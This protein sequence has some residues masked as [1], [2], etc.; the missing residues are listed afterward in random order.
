[1]SMRDPENP[2]PVFDALHIPP[3]ALEQGG[4]EVLRAVIVE[5]DLHLSLRRAFDEPE[6]WG[7]LLAEIARHVGHL[8]AQEGAISE[9]EVVERV[10]DV[11]ENE[12]DTQSNSGT[13]HTVS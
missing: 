9:K 6:T 11:F 13:S 10:R 2:S 1:M 7:M 4:T 3:A 5:G 8:Y 12:I